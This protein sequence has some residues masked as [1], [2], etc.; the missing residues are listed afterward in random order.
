MSALG[1]STCAC[2]N[3]NSLSISFEQQLA[4]G[5]DR[6]DREAFGK[7]PMDVPKELCPPTA[8]KE[9]NG[10]RLL[11]RVFFVL[12]D[13]TTEREEEPMKR[14]L[15]LALAFILLMSAFA[16]FDS[17]AVAAGSLGTD[18][19][20]HSWRDIGRTMQ[21]TCTDYGYRTEECTIC[22]QDRQVPL[23]PLGHYFP[24]PWTTISEP[25][26]TEAGH[27]MNTCVRVNRGTPCGF[28]WWREIPALG[29]D[30]GD[31]L[32]HDTYLVRFC[33]RCGMSQQKSSD[34]AESMLVLSG[35]KEGN[36][37]TLSVTNTGTEDIVSVTLLMRL[38]D[39][40]DTIFASDEITPAAWSYLPAGHTLTAEMDLPPVPEFSD[41]DV[42]HAVP[43]AEAVYT[44]KGTPASNDASI[45][46]DP[47]MAQIM[48]W[49]VAP[50]MEKPGLSLS[51]TITSISCHPTGWYMEGETV[52]YEL[53]V[54]NE[55]PNDISD[56]SLFEDLVPGTGYWKTLAYLPAG[57]TEHLT[58]T[59][60]PT[61]EDCSLYHLFN[62][63]S[64]FWK[65]PETEEYR[66]AVSQTTHASLRTAEDAAEEKEEPDGVTVIKELV[67]K[68][69]DPLGRFA[70]DEI[71]KFD[72][73][74]TNN[75]DC[76]LSN[77]GLYDLHASNAA[78]YMGSLT[79]KPHE[80]KTRAFTIPIKM[81]EEGIHYEIGFHDH[82]FN[83]AWVKYTDPITGKQQTAN[84]NLV[85]VPIM[86]IDKVTVQKTV[87]NSA[88]RSDGRF[89]PGEEIVFGIT[90]TN[91]AP[92]KIE[93]VRIYDGLDPETCWKI[94]D[95]EANETLMLKYKYAPTLEECQTG[96]LINTATA[97]WIDNDNWNRDDFFRSEPV[98]VELTDEPLP[99]K[100]SCKRTLISSFGDAVVWRVD[101]CSRHSQ[102]LAQSFS[103]ER[104]DPA[105][106][107]AWIREIDSLYN[108]MAATTGN[109]AIV[110]AARNAWHA[111]H[112]ALR[113]VCELNDS[114]P[115][116]CADIL[117]QDTVLHCTE[118]CSLT[119]GTLSPTDPG[120]LLSC[121]GDE[122]SLLLQMDETGF[123]LT[124]DSC[125]A[126]TFAHDLS[127]LLAESQNQL[128]DFMTARSDEAK[129]AMSVLDTAQSEW[130][131][132]YRALLGICYSFDFADAILASSIRMAMWQI[133]ALPLPS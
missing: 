108:T 57:K 40:G 46:S 60:I 105:M 43:Y 35:L 107:N 82:L 78:S 72:I 37:V 133:C 68:P 5:V 89:T 50:A 99:V 100:E 74:I 95:L 7:D 13:M 114:E 93:E 56:I 123:T 77:M 32:R 84:S 91:T 6:D 121:T 31:W 66:T 87:L 71:V 124:L 34:A 127:S 2:Y 97:V 24:N 38:T 61:K 85:F 67:S 94:L 88:Q 119:H 132:A 15:S 29:H 80:S 63:A 30:W 75:T 14:L 21:P 125:A 20:T 122:C 86:P 102:M 33:A 25:T 45:L 42:S 58:Y 4:K 104:D 28:E 73:T 131:A 81:D 106:E 16:A 10:S 111:R 116:A 62:A 69:A 54:T 22:Q 118:L 52:T 129:A 53:A 112:E 120:D 23:N 103:V 44:A 65:D 70:V 8:V 39:G 26:C 117:L 49:A 36:T 76:T 128:S 79:L 55:T 48:P 113:G 101:C 110:L 126:H 130:F 51:Q 9:I 115:T 19:H 41:G 98:R 90:L 12:N 59:Y 64:A 17:A 1:K 96:F 3:V 27:E 47:W 83:R 109:S 11:C 18:G 92:Y